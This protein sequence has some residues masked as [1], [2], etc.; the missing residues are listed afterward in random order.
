MVISRWHRR[1][2]GLLQEPLAPICRALS[3]DNG[4]HFGHC[5]HVSDEREVWVFSMI[6]EATAEDAEKA[7]EAM[8]RALCPDENH[9]G[10]CAVPWTL[11]RS[12][13]E[14]LDD[15]ERASWAE[16]FEQ[17]RQEW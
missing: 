8:Q 7:A 6:I 5:D 13:F 1:H 16:I 15:D 4:I 9:S 3:L 12:R 2:G 17:D 14:D 10:P 11:M